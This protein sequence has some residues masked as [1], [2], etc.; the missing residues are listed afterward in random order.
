MC[1]S[2]RGKRYWTQVQEASHCPNFVSTY[3]PSMGF[4][5]IPLVYQANVLQPDHTKP[6]I[7][8]DCGFS[9]VKFVCQ[10][11]LLCNHEVYFELL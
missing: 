6:I 1:M 8:T 3:M 4:K 5:P 9:G 10:F 11:E 2:S 7:I